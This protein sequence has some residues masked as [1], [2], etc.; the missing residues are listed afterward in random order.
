MQNGH[1]TQIPKRALEQTSKDATQTSKRTST[2]AT[3]ALAQMLTVSG[4]A[5]TDKQQVVSIG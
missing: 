2:D 4:N 1:W 3:R 5:N